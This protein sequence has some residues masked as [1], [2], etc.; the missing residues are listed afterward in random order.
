MNLQFFLEYNQFFLQRIT[1]LC[2]LLNKSEEQLRKIL[3]GLVTSESM[4]LSVLLLSGDTPPKTP[5]T[6]VSCLVQV[7]LYQHVLSLR[8]NLKFQIQQKI[9]F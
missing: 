1:S 7:F 5:P 9:H 4:D 6:N 8:K 3:Q 2:K